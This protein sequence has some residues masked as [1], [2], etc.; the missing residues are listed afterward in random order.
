[1]MF[2]LVIMSQIVASEYDWFAARATA[3]SAMRDAVPHYASLFEEEE[4]GGEEYD[5]WSARAMAR[6]GMRADADYASL[7]AEEETE[8]E[9]RVTGDFDWWAARAN[10]RAAHRETVVIE[11]PKLF[12]FRRLFK[13][14]TSPNM[15]EFPTIDIQYASTNGYT[16]TF[17]YTEYEHNEYSQYADEDEDEYADHGVDQDDDEYETVCDSEPVYC[18]TCQPC[19]TCDA[20]PIVI[21]S[22]CEDEVAS[23]EALRVLTS[24]RRL[25][26]RRAAMEQQQLFKLEIETAY[27]NATAARKEVDA[28]R[29]ELYRVSLS[30]KSDA[31]RMTFQTEALGSIIENLREDVADETM[32]RAEIQSLEMQLMA[33]ERETTEALEERDELRSERRSAELSARQVAV[34]R[35][36]TDAA[37][38][39]I[40]T[41]LCVFLGKAFLRNHAL[42]K[43]LND[44]TGA[45]AIAP[46]TDIDERVKKAE[47]A[48][49]AARKELKDIRSKDKGS[50]ALIS[51]AEKAREAAARES[52]EAK[53]RATAAAKAIA[54]H[55]ARANKA[56]QAVAKAE[57]AASAAMQA[58]AEAAKR[59]AAV[60]KENAEAKVNAEKVAARAEK[61]EAEAATA[62][63]ALEELMAEIARQKKE[64]AQMNSWE[65]V[66]V[67]TSASPNMGPAA[68]P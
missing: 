57:A 42:S 39:V 7:F 12:N 28:V 32:L 6:S 33:S 52:V 47:A 68:N 23:L 40:I 20:C 30:Y 13:V 64:E 15:V 58:G 56:E 11:A 53:V 46:S 26:E 50:S 41:A 48:S 61:A 14:F 3:R 60:S 19:E 25:L 34:M 24:E 10:A 21:N 66:S 51:T 37:Y 63:A 43:Q 54:E 17:E 1:M 35:K 67:S 65:V 38:L 59:V 9:E 27:A 31:Q 62:T 18:E 29:K 36:L 2:S 8:E 55:K 16:E 44:T 5:W 22:C 4:I 45:A 49:V